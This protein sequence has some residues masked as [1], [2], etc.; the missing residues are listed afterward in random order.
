M[1]AETASEDASLT[2]L[3]IVSLLPSAT[4]IVCALGLADALVGVTHECDF[5]PQAVGK[6]IVTRSA[7]DGASLTSREIDDAVRAKQESGTGVYEI[8]VDLLS[9]LKPDLVLTQGLCDVCAVSHSLV[10]QTVPRLPS[11][12]QV[13][14]LSPQHLADVVRGEHADELPVLDDGEGP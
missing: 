12:P 6:P 2:P 13:L 7:L 9:E 3:R 10:R 8:D 4:E 11:K 1:T 14:S 5:P